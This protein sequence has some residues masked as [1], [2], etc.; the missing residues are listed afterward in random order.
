MASS[1]PQS[2]DV[3]KTASCAD[4][5][6]LSYSPAQGDCAN[7]MAELPNTRSG[8]LDLLRAVKRAVGGADSAEDLLH[9]AFVRLS[10]YSAR[11]AV[12]VQRP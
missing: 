10:E 6:A 5:A 2:N 9:S 7:N 1:K 3:A 4:G 12:R 11:E 8:W